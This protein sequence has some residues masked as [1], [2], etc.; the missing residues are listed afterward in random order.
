MTATPVNVG[1][2]VA[3]VYPIATGVAHMIPPLPPFP[4]GHET[5]EPNDVVPPVPPGLFPAGPAIPGA[6]IV[7][8]ALANPAVMSAFA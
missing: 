7:T 8:G 3:I 2:A 1:A 5:N 4:P 6:P